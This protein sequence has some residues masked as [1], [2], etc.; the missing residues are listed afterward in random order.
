MVEFSSSKKIVLI[1]KFLKKVKLNN[2]ISFNMLKN[3]L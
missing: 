3:I 2:Q 1:L